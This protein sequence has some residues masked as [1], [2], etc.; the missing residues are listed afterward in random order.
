M[1]DSWRN[2]GYPKF[3]AKHIIY[4]FLPICETWSLSSVAKESAHQSTE[5][6]HMK[7]DTWVSTEVRLK[8]LSWA[9]RMLKN[10]MNYAGYTHLL[11]GFCHM[12]L[13]FFHVFLVL[14][15]WLRFQCLP[16]QVPLWSTGAL[17]SCGEFSLCR[18]LRGRWCSWPVGN[19][20]ENWHWWEI[21]QEQQRPNVLCLKGNKSIQQKQ[22]C[23]F[24][25]KI[26]EKQKE[27]WIKLSSWGVELD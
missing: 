23:F 1:T 18:C 26:L 7:V 24:D 3:G 5:W 22:R 20:L 13:H 2:G 19:S 16:Y 21:N 12:T 4:C 8:C 27:T 14:K 15:Q 6:G 25:V 17:W 9:L 10:C 11:P